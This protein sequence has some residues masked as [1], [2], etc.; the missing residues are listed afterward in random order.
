[1]THGAGMW[2]GA[3][4]RRVPPFNTNLVLELAVVTYCVVLNPEAQPAV[5]AA[6]LRLSLALSPNQLPRMPPAF[7]GSDHRSLWTAAGE[8]GDRGSSAPGHVEVGWSSPTG[9]ALI[10]SL[11]MGESTVKDRGFGTSPAT[12]CRVPTIKVRNHRQS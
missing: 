2:A 7:S 9:S 1:M 4:S 12:R 8:R 3:D 5:S 11:R 6:P 10:Q